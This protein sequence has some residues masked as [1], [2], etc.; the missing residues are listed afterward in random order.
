MRNFFQFFG[1]R[2]PLQKY[3]P[4]RFYQMGVKLTLPTVAETEQMLEKTSVQLVDSQHDEHVEV[5]D[6]DGILGEIQL[7]EV[8]AVQACEDPLY[9]QMQAL[10][11][12]HVE[13]QLAIVLDVHLEREEDLEAVDCDRPHESVLVVAVIL[14][15]PH[16]SQGM[17]SVVDALEVASSLVDKPAVHDV[18]VLHSGRKVQLMMDILV[19]VNVV[20]EWSVESE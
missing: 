14:V 16:Q 5:Q 6:V 4:N 3:Q 11:E 8:H 12:M 1:L 19:V 10:D 9:E 7:V 13:M 17:E 20:Q 15:A 2:T 18:E